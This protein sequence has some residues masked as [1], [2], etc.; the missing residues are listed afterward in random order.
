MWYTD[1]IYFPANSERMLKLA[2]LYRNLSP[3]A[4]PT[5]PPN[6]P[7]NQVELLVSLFTDD[8]PEE[9]SWIF[10]EASGRKA[11]V[12]TNYQASAGQAKMSLLH[13]VCVRAVAQYFLIVS[14]SK[15]DGMI[16][17]TT[18]GTWSVL[19]SDPFIIGSGGKFKYH[20]IAMAGSPKKCSRGYKNFLFLMATDNSPSE[21]SW[22]LKMSSGT[23]VAKSPL[24]SYQS[25][26]LVFFEK[27]LRPNLTYVFELNDSGEDGMC[28][29]D[30]QGFIDV[31]LDGVRLNFIEDEKF[32]QQL[33]EFD[34]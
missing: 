6:C 22:A 16:G 2:P 25:S 17:K 9:T 12:V 30:G 29:V 34:T 33:I 18:N 13:I 11:T 8:K 28:C 31:R 21:T 24:Q 5:L 7:V 23:I 14:D 32:V 10:V 20:Q 27:C 19:T 1:E 26:S 15:G 3:Q 4:P